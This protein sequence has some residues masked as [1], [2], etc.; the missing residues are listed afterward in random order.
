M[1][2][3]HGGLTLSCTCASLYGTQRFAG[4]DQG[5]QVFGSS[6]SV[7]WDTLAGTALHSLQRAPPFTLELLGD[8][9]ERG[10]GPLPSPR[11]RSVPCVPSSPRSAPPGACLF[12]PPE[13]TL[14]CPWHLFPATVPLPLQAHGA[15]VGICSDFSEQGHRIRDVRASRRGSEPLTMLLRPGGHPGTDRRLRTSLPHLPGQGPSGL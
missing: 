5:G 15:D 2:A 3:G 14:G 6:W 4:L 8:P 9:S 13:P 7:P 12:P 1:P 10:P 11:P